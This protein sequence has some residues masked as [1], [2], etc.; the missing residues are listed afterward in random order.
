M[1]ISIMNVHELTDDKHREDKEKCYNIIPRY[2]TKLIAEDFN[3][4]MNKER[5]HKPYI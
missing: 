1:K 5:L 3:V 2:V 4:K